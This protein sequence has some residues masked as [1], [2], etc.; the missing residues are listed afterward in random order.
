MP[1][2]DE[3]NSRDWRRDETGAD[4]GCSIR[5][6]AP[7]R[8]TVMARH[9]CLHHHARTEVLAGRTVRVDLSIPVGTSVVRGSV[10][11]ASGE[12]VAGAVVMLD[13]EG[14][15]DAYVATTDEGGHFRMDDVA[16]GE[17]PATAQGAGKPPLRRRLRVP[18]HADV[19]LEFVFGRI[20][21]RGTVTDGSSGLPVESAVVALTSLG[22]TRRSATTDAAGA[23]GIEDLEP[24]E[25]CVL[26]VSAKGF[27]RLLRADVVVDPDGSTLD[28]RLRPCARLTLIVSGAGGEP[29]CG[30]VSVTTLDLEGGVTARAMTSE[31]R[32]DDRGRIVHEGVASGRYLVTV[33]AKPLGEGQASAEVDLGPQGNEL[34]LTLR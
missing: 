7:G 21:L 5:D 25:H 10:R 19:L 13:R 20:L 32:T 30:R 1:E 3:R 18:E 4:G 15:T 28:L 29:F 14:S 9:G 6:L 31:L 12:P 16:A 23:Y 27:A 8:F 22:G 2:G 11:H 33:R 17:Y 24:G 26:S 34:R